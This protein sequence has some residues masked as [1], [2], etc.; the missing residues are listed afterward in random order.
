MIRT[1][2]LDDRPAILDVVRA[3]FGRE[4]EVALV[5]RIWTLDEYV[6]DLDLVA[7]VDGTVVGHV[8]HS[9]G[10]VGEHRLLGLAPLAVHPDHQRDGIGTT[11][12]REAIARANAAGHTAIVLLGH[13]DYYAR[14]GFRPAR[15]LGIASAIDLPSD[16]DPFMALPL[17]AYDPAIRGTF[18][19]AWDEP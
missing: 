6:P 4:D 1:A 8:L 18:R 7:L 11:L 3:A 9:T 14:V 10:Y 19:Y 13:P 16:P 2:T 17:D 5:E 15:E 12:L